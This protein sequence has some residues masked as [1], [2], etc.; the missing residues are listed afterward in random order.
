MPLSEMP[1]LV[2]SDT[3][4]GTCRHQALV[5]AGV[6]AEAFCH[7]LLLRCAVLLN[8]FPC[9]TSHA[10]VPAHVPACLPACLPVCLCADEHGD[11]H[12]EKDRRLLTER[13][14]AADENSDG[15]LDLN[16]LNG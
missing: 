3:I 7:T 14:R 4:P 2:M 12:S 8:L 6:G 11:P 13:F 1:I 9:L 10:C 15:K 5:D 16:E